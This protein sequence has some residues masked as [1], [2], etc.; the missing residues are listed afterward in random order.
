MKIHRL[1]FILVC[2][3]SPMLAQEQTLF[4]GR[5]DHGGFGGPI[6]QLTQIDDQTGVLIGGHG[7]WIINHVVYVGGG[8]VGLANEIE[9]S[10]AADSL[11]YL[12]LGYGGLELGVI[13]ASNKLVHFTVSSLI[14]GGGVNYRG[15][16]WDGDYQAGTIDDAFFVLE[17]ALHLE[18]NVTK[19]MRVALGGSYRYVSG[20]DLEGLS[21]SMISG[22]SASLTF[23]FGRF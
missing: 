7:G 2:L 11:P 9:V 21:D 8:G 4:T 16:S 14:G 3:L 12:N 19:N 18:L 20:I 6:L 10:S 17:P 15:T 22:P 1:T 23:K 13:L 5:I